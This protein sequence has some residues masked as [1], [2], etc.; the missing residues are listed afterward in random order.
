MLLCSYNHFPTQNEIEVVVEG[1]CCPVC[2][3]DWVEAVNPKPEGV[4]GQP[5]ELTCKVTGVE[6]TAKDIFW[7]M[8][9]PTTDVA[10]IKKHYEVSA[11]GLTLTIKKLNEKRA[12]SYQLPWQHIIII[13]SF[14]TA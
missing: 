10:A 4:G 13:F 1:K 11:D 5:L 14:I 2:Q 8:L 7:V 9:N 3:E 12:G 6:V